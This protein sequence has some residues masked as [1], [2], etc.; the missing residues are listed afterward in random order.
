MSLILTGHDGFSTPAGHIGPQFKVDHDI[1]LLVPEIWARLRPAQRKASWL[2]GQGYMERVEDF[3]HQGRRVLASRLGYRITERFVAHFMGKIFDNPRAVFSEAI[4]KPESRIWRASST[5]S[6]TSSRPRSGSR[7]A[8]S[9]TA[10]SRK[11]ARR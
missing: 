4:L 8:T 1:S 11:P 7:A 10:A 2:I 6:T 3:E 5:A 9:R